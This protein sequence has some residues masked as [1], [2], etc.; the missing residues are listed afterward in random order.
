MSG[1][2][3]DASP[4]SPQS[5]APPAASPAQ[6]ADTRG[7]LRAHGIVPRKRWGQNFLIR[8]AILDQIVHRWDLSPGSAVLEVGAGAGSLTARLLARGA[9]VLAIERDPR[10]CRLL[11][12]RFVVESAGGRFALIEGDVLAITRAEWVAAAERLPGAGTMTTPPPG[13]A[14][15]TGAATAAGAA[16]G[17]KFVGN[18]PYS[19]TTPILEW[20]I[21]QKGEFEW[22]AYMVQREYAAR[23]LASP[24][25]SAYGSL[26]LWMG[27]HF[28]AEKE[29]AVG[30]ACF[31]PIPRVES[32]VVRLTPWDS[33][34]VEVPSAE[35]YERVVRAAFA[36]RR[37]M[38]GG[39]LSL[40]LG[41]SRDAVEAMLRSAGLDPRQRA[42]QYDAASFAR[43]ARAFQA[44]QSGGAGRDQT[45]EP[46][47]NQAHTGPGGERPNV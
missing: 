12:E 38:V 17:W 28:R 23:L 16:R 27:Y 3:P 22:A 39:A 5:P 9:R 7:Y 42:E 19:I 10:L 32:A 25:S 35:P 36:H 37:K 46:R 14:A 2:T 43:L 47:E 45:P 29:M 26:T 34:P 1:D 24:G 31:W 4:P 8:P 44:A 30:A 18:L 6:V 13:S 20:T 33:P 21:G 11:R 41:L 15:A 40:A